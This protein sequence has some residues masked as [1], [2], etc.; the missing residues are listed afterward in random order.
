MAHYAIGDVQGC[1]QELL[2]LLEQIHFDSRRDTLLFTGDLVNR[3]PDS[4]ATLR[5]VRDLGEQAVVVLGN[6]D[7]HL[8]AV[9]SGAEA[10][11]SNDTLSPVL[12]AP[13][14]DE[15]CQWLVTRP[16]LHYEP[17][18][19]S[20]LVHAGIWPKW[21]RDTAISCAD[22]VTQVLRSPNCVAFFKRMYGDKPNNWSD[23]LAGW[24]RLRFIVNAFTR[25][26]FVTPKGK[27]VLDEKRA[28]SQV[29]S[30][31]I[32]WFQFPRARK[33]KSKIMFGHWASLLGATRSEQHIGL[34]TGCVWGGYLTAIRLDDGHRFSTPSLQQ[35]VW[36]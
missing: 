21:D 17:E 27:L 26:R 23:D 32:P 12:S 36:L 10:L 2:N 28:P 22:E 1:Y 3:G 7:L 24:D 9:V 6:H 19:D 16:L 20:L 5:F 25:M 34:D 35:K 4:L 29:A 14:R 13:D 30:K 11:R 33:I 8:L 31:L 15:L 18:F